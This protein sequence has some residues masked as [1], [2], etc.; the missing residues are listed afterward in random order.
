MTMI[1]TIS[2]VNGHT[3]T[4][5]LPLVGQSFTQSGGEIA[6]ARPCPICGEK[7]EAL[8]GHYEKGQYDDIMV[9]VDLSPKAVN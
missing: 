1:F 7:L 2:C 5:S 9:L 8:S 6:H 4:V 3:G